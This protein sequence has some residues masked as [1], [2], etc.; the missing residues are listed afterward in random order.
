ME[1]GLDYD[2]VIADPS[3]AKSEQA[4]KMYNVDISPS[5]F[6]KELVIPKFLTEEQ[7]RQV[8]NK[9][10]ENKDLSLSL[11]PVKGVLDY[12]PK[13]LKELHMVTVITSRHSNSADVAQEWLVKNSLFIPV[14]GV[15]YPLPKTEACRGLDV[16]VDDDLDKL[17]PLID[18]VPNR[19]LF[20]QPY[21]KHE[22]LE[23]IAKRIDTWQNLYFEIK[24]LNH[25]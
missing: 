1:I 6:K 23:S 17:A 22:D 20:S 19:Y 15:P 11:P 21:N 12:L 7:Y 3:K 2:G 18:I 14:I 25:K 13:L 4:K 16:Y 24:R 8:Q 5:M 10:Y 9:V